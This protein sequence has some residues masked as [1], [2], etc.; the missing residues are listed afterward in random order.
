MRS[1][2]KRIW[3]PLA[4]VAVATLIS[5]GLSA[6]SGDQKS[7]EGADKVIT[8]NGVEPEDVLVP[9]EV[10]NQ[11]GVKILDLIFSGLVSYGPKGEVNNE[12][13]KDITHSEDLKT[14][15][16][17]LNED[18]KFADGT[19]VKAENFVK[20]WVQSA[21]QNLKATTAFSV[22][23]GTDDS[24]AGNMTGAKVTGDYEIQ[25]K[26]KEPVS[27]F[28]T[29]LGVNCYYPLPNSAFKDNGEINKD[30]GKN[31]VGNGPYK[32]AKW[33]HEKLISLRKSDSYRGIRKL[34]NDGI[35]F[36][37]YEKPE[38]AYNELLSGNLDIL[39]RIPDGALS[40][41]KVELK[42]RSMSKPTGALH[43]LDF[44]FNVKHFQGEEG[45]LRRRAISQAI[46]RK[47]IVDT[48][49][50]GTR[51]VATDFL[52]PQLSAHQQDLAGGEVLKF[53]PEQAK[54]DWAAANQIS[55]WTGKFTISY[56]SDDNHQAWVE[57]VVN[58]LK[59]NLGLDAQADPVPSFKTLGDKF[60]EKDLPGGY[61]MGWTIGYPSASNL[62][63]GRYT[64]NSA[65]NVANYYNE[66][67]EDLLKQAQ[68]AASEEKSKE[69]YTQAQ[70]VLL[71]D[72][73]SVPLWS[74][75]N[76]IGWGERVKDVTVDWKGDVAYEKVRV[77]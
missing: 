67:F 58:Q 39:D 15:T 68:A 69:L 65:S 31:P 24:G 4:V 26:L 20:A 61:R 35:D 36:K 40:T 57:A 8:V 23:E 53:N 27:D 12:I 34:A 19:P 74:P 32:I 2:N 75:A 47:R 71:A 48:I 16:I 70:E 63:Q 10:N 59:T 41:F 52:P 29:R 3:R 44:G 6:C 46:D 37:L 9:A 73:A 18:R 25:V 62:L 51:M 33:E 5:A 38:T 45:T 49:F 7:A 30:F 14:W 43:T 55:P 21:K 54:K 60:K 50:K 22:I 64:K 11:N 13:A 72:M 17:K 56:N 77:E 76:N 42:G 1:P 28:P 66:K